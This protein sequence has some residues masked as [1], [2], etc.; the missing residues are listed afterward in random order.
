MAD[1]ARPKSN[2]AFSATP[3]PVSCSFWG[4]RDQVKGLLGL[5]DDLQAANLCRANFCC[6]PHS[7]TFPA[8]A[9]W[10]QQWTQDAPDSGPTTGRRRSTAHH[11]AAHLQLTRLL[12]CAHMLRGVAA[13][14][15]PISSAPGTLPTPLVWK[16]LHT[17]THTHTHSLLLVDVGLRRIR[18]MYPKALA[19]NTPVEEQNRGGCRVSQTHGVRCRKSI[20]RKQGFLRLSEGRL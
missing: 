20:L 4:I 3:A 14:L 11:V 10:K 12:G 19:P 8:V 13:L 16:S 5:S 1:A 2:D 18:S 6:I 7:R 9:A 15:L 17:H